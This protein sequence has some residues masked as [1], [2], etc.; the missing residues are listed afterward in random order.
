MERQT[1]NLEVL[2]VLVLILG[3]NVL[4]LVGQLMQAVHFRL[5]NIDEL[6]IQKISALCGS[7]PVPFFFSLWILAASLSS[8]CPRKLL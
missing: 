2:L 1:Y 5:L 7:T 4:S 3:V 8:F 6:Y